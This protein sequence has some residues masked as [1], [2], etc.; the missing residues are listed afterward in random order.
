MSITNNN[1]KNML[2][3]LKEEKRRMFF[4]QRFILPELQIPQSIAHKNT[5]MPQPKQGPSFSERAT[6]SF[7]N[8]KSSIQT[9]WQNLNFGGTK[10]VVSPSSTVFPVEGT[11]IGRV[12]LYPKFGPLFL[13]QLPPNNS[14]LEFP[15]SPIPIRVSRHYCV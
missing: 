11:R 12:T 6:K 7:S 8:L 4:G 14:K 2:S 1:N 9:K 5:I 3:L 13:P 15:T 10:R